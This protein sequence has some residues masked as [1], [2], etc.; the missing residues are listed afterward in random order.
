LGLTPA[1]TLDS[2]GFPRRGQQLLGSADVLRGPVDHALDVGEVGEALLDLQHHGVQRG[3]VDRQAD[4]QNPQGHLL[5]A[6]RVG[7]L[8]WAEEGRKRR[9][10]LTRRRGGTTPGGKE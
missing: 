2:L 9:T 5:D 4:G 7:S 10:S 6:L 3:P 8:L 1:L